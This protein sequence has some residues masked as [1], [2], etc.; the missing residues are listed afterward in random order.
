M[1]V[2]KATQPGGHLANRRAWLSDYLQ[3]SCPDRYRSNV[4]IQTGVDQRSNPRAGKA[5]SALLKRQQMRA[6]LALSLIHI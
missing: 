2:N 3:T 5:G 1:S 6:S 4:R